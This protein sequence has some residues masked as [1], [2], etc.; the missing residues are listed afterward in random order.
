MYSITTRWHENLIQPGTTMLSEIQADILEGDGPMES[1]QQSNEDDD[2]S[3]DLF[4]RQGCH[5][6]YSSL[7]PECYNDQVLKYITIYVLPCPR[8]TY[9]RPVNYE[10]P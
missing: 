1:E 6:F 8:I 4:L 7:M 5:P 2:K 3:N 9:N 10:Y